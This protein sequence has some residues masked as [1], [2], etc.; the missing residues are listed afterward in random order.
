MVLRIPAERRQPTLDG[1]CFTHL[2]QLPGQTCRCLPRPLSWLHPRER[3]C[4]QLRW[5]RTLPTDAPAVGLVSVLSPSQTRLESS[6]GAGRARA[7][8]TSAPGSAEPVSMSGTEADEQ[9]AFP[10]PSRWAQR[11]PEGPAE[12]ESQGWLGITGFE[13]GGVGLTQGRGCL[14]G[15]KAEGASSLQSLQEG[16]GLRRPGF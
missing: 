5:S 2:H 7:P 12:P 4:F 15:R 11:H 13:D 3:G 16:P 1:V 14:S 8:E 6:P 9:L 10:G